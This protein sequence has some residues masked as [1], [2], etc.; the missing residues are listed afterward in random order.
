MKPNAEKLG[1]KLLGSDHIADGKTFQLRQDHVKI[2]GTDEPLSYE[3]EERAE[4]VIIVPVTRERREVLIRQYRYPV[5]EWYLETPAGGCHDTG[6][7]ALAEVARKELHE[8]IGATG[9]IVS[10]AGS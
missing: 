4:S 2:P 7:K 3:Y 6:D 9:E 8:E 10:V 5:D 1:W